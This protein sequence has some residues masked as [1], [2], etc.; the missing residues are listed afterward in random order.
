MLLLSTVL[1][2]G[3]GLISSQSIYDGVRSTEKAKAVVND[4]SRQELP[5]YDDYERQRQR[6]REPITP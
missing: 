2:T 3:C 1:L 6:Q 5:P 4:K